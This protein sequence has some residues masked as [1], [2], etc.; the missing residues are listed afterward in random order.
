M[1]VL[2]PWNI[3]MRT[4]IEGAP[5]DTP[6]KP[7]KTHQAQS[8]SHPFL[9]KEIALQAGVSDATVD[10]VLNKRPGVRRHTIQRVRRAIKELEGQSEQS[11][12]AGRKFVIDV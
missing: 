6:R 7:S 11:S 8:M 5:A 4:S 2:P 12:M 1:R 10:R 9:I 3:D